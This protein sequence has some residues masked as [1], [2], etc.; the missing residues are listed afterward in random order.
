MGNTGLRA[1]IQRGDWDRASA[2]L[3]TVDGRHRAST[4]RYTDELGETVTALH[5]ACQH[6]APARVMEVLIAAGQPMA[7]SSPNL[8]SAL[9]Y[10]MM[11]N[12][13]TSRQ[14]VKKLVDAFPSDVSKQSSPAMGSKTPLHLAC[15]AKVPHTIIQILFETDPAASGIRDASGRT[16]L[17]IAC[18]H[19]WIF[20]P[21]W[22]MRVN[23]ILRDEHHPH[24]HQLQEP[25]ATPAPHHSPILLDSSPEITDNNDDD[26]AAD[27]SK[28]DGVCVLCW[29]KKADMALIPCGH[30]CLCSHCSG[31]PRI[32]NDTLQR[33]CPVCRHVFSQEPL[34]IYQAGIA[35]VE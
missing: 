31:Q 4:K 34:K 24:R 15:E 9:H 32:L 28:D 21:L 27:K 22:R 7:V 13:A 5:L 25:A 12:R 3:Q 10:A 30:V 14:I 16:A 20:N 19:S 26:G 17:E 18:S 35:G 6:R 11:T 33:K 1:S 29:E 23:K 8:L 2:I